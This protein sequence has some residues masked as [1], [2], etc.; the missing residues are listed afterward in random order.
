MIN[1]NA[2]LTC[3]TCLSVGL[4]PF[5]PNKLA[6]KGSFPTP[7]P[8]P[9]PPPP[10]IGVPPLPLPLPL[11]VFGVTPVKE[12]QLGK[13]ELVPAEKDERPVLEDGPGVGVLWVEELE[14]WGSCFEDWN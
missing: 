4:D 9:P 13:E 5:P 3:N 12:L 6:G 7:R 2:L 14:D 8:P 10:A 11:P 1:E